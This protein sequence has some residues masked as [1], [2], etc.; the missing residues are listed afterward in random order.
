LYFVVLVDVH[1]DRWKIM[2]IKA[3]IRG[4]CVWINVKLSWVVLNS[5]ISLTAIARVFYCHIVTTLWNSSLLSLFIFHKFFP[6]FF[7]GAVNSDNQEINRQEIYWTFL[8]H[9]IAQNS[10]TIKPYNSELENSG[11]ILVL[12]SSQLHIKSK[13]MD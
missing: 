2:A 9:F 5:L 8:F 6:H 13:A 7:D 3:I 11:N 12:Q 4:R 1:Y 10:H